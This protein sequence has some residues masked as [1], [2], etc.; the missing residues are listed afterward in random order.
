MSV[1]DR[2]LLL[3]NKGF[4]A[5]A[6]AQFLGALNDNA[7]KVLVTLLLAGWAPRPELAGRYVSAAGAIF[8]IPFLL[9]STHAG[10]L[11]DRFSKMR[12]ALWAKALEIM[13][14]A[15]S[16]WAFYARSEIFL[17]GVLF[18]MGLQSALFGPAKYGILP[19][20]LE[21]KDLSN[22][23]GILQMSTF[24]AILGGTLLAGP[25]LEKTRD[26]LHLASLV[27]V[28]LAALG[29]LSAF[30]ITPV[31]ASGAREKF[32]WNPAR[33]FL[34]DWR[35]AS[36]DPV[37]TR[38]LLG[39]GAFWM[40]GAIFQMDLLLYGKIVM[41][42]GDTAISLYLAVMAV[43]IGLGSAAAGLLSGRKVELGLV[44]LGTI[45]MGVFS[46]D[47][48]FASHSQAR[49]GL[50]LA[51]VGF[52]AGFFVIPLNALLQQRSPRQA[53]GKMV[54][55]ANIVSIFGV[56]AASL[57]MWLLTDLARLDPA[58]TLAVVAGLTFL[59][60]AYVVF[61]LRVSL[62]RFL[63][64][65]LT[66]TIYRIE[67]S[68]GG[69][70]PLR[71]PALIVCNHVSYVD[72]FLLTAAVSRNVRFFMWRKIYEWGPLRWFFKM[73][74]MI[75]IS[76]ADGPR[77]FAASML[78]ARRALEEGHVVAIFAEGAITRVGQTLGFKKGME[79]IVKGLD[80]PVIPAHLDRVWGSIFSFRGG[81]FL[82]KVPRQIPY[83][84][85]VSFGAPL[86]AP[87][88]A[89]AARQAVLELGSDAFARRM[90]EL[91]TLPRALLRRARRRWFSKAAADTTGLSLTYG[92]FLA[93]AAHYAR[94]FAAAGPEKAAGD[95]ER[96]GVLFP[97][98]VPGALVNAALS[99]AGKIPVNLNFTLSRELLENIMDKA[100][101]RRVVT[102]ARMLEALK[103]ERDGRFLCLEDVP[104]PSKAS[105]A[106]LWILLRLLPPRLSEILL[107]PRSRARPGDPATLMFTSGSTGEPKGVIITHANIH[108]N[109]QGMLEVF[110]MTPRD[111]LAGV[112][113]FFHSFG[114]T[115]TLWFPLL[116]GFP[117]VYHRSPL[118]AA[119]IQKMIRSHGATMALATPTFLQ[120][121]LRKFD[122]EDVGTLR[123]VLAGAEKLRESLA[124]E[125]FDKLGVQVLEG[126]GCTELSPAACVNA[127]DVRDRHENQSGRKAGTVGRPLPGVSV[128]V[129]HPETG[130]GL[131]PGEP[132]LLLVKGPNVMKGY[133]RDP[134]KTAEVLRDGWYVTGD[135]ASVDDDGFI[136]ITDRLSRFSK[137]GGEM[138]PHILVEEKL[139]QVCGDPQAQ[140]IVVSLPD[141]KRGEVLAV[142]HY[143]FSGD[144]AA[145]CT[146]LE[147]AGLPNLWIPDP[148]RF[149]KLDQWPALG[150]GKVDL[151]GARETARRLLAGAS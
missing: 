103:W 125:F 86:P 106:A 140:F 30:F 68:G 129:V 20:M 43:G 87:A 92:K 54:A 48:A 65:L 110:Q 101:I 104:K 46:L 61:L 120:M 64:W 73:M 2:P 118:E 27:F 75:P 3:R 21:D 146:G 119:A 45:G 15:L 26:Q 116:G 148:R 96:V 83:P 88:T 89:V 10:F 37:L 84:V 60:S 82:W 122:K 42:A 109:V 77:R 31:P 97:P 81:R 47:L 14:M 71:G 23:N 13:V 9:F 1:S 22:G 99:L 76:A 51:L 39:I 124:K 57:A 16:F 112:L 7:F 121:W 79:V 141:E 58:R 107:L 128:R 126:Y 52:F 137:I 102:S 145:L 41:G 115:G 114:Y 131:P 18:L 36:R 149:L 62:A 6:V 5:L 90:D 94:R 100:G 40:I 69:N 17:A 8:V 150:T 80:V 63:L 142:L 25:L 24:L 85:T 117:V 135:I 72:P 139:H 55:L 35:E 38:C 59:L 67:V 123:V 78:E 147:A 132:G 32:D 56:L 4:L 34:R 111:V 91:P 134:A 143:N 11:S 151:A 144:P 53:K 93:A 133:W 28:G 44:P 33:Q 12:V 127:P 66:H 70:V 29:T 98:S 113:P 130:L 136:R 49:V 50:D 105:A 138:V 74:G 95:A 19:E 108:A